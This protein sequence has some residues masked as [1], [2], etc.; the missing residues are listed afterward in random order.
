MQLRAQVRLAHMQRQ[1][2]EIWERKMVQQVHQHHASFQDHSQPHRTVNIV[3]AI[4]I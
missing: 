2:H 1:L 3:E 4:K